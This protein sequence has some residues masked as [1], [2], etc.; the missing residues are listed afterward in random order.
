MIKK[1]IDP[2]KNFLLKKGECIGEHVTA[3]E[4]Q[5]LYK[6]DDG[7]LIVLIKYTSP[8]LSD[9]LKRIEPATAMYKFNTAKLGFFCA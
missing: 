7:R 6:L 2:T 4:T 8:M 1:G 9:Q 5:Q 3:T